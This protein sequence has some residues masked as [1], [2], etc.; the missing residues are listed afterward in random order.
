[1]AERLTRLYPLIAAKNIPQSH[2]VASGLCT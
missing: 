1:M 2:A